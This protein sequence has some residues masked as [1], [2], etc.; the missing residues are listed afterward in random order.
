MAL[1]DKDIFIFGLPKFD[2]EIEST[3]FT[4]ARHLA[5]NNRV[6]YI[7]N[8]YTWKDS[9]LQ[10]KQIDHKRRKQQYSFASIG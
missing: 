3:I 2:S 1:R 7:E 9:I 6:F 5:R 10:R 8:P 4:L